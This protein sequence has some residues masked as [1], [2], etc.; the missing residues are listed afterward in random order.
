[1]Y[2]VVHIS[3]GIVAVTFNNRQ[4][5]LDWIADNNSLLDV[6]AEIYKLIKG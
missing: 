6:Y 2:K 1:M 5:A 3:S 4:Y